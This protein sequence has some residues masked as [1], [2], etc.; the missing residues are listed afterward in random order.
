MIRKT[1]QKN[2]IALLPEEDD[3]VYLTPLEKKVIH[4]CSQLYKIKTINRKRDYKVADLK[5][6]V[7]NT[8]VGKKVIKE[9]EDEGI[10]ETWLRNKGQ[11]LLAD[12]LG[13]SLS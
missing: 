4:I 12:V 13:A 6:L 10:D 5:K 9:L 3:D 8:P 11:I 7:L 2:G 1:K